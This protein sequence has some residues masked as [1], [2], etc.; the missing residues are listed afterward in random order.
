MTQSTAHYTPAQSP[1]RWIAV[2]LLHLLLGW[3]LVSGTH[4][5]VLKALRQPM[6]TLL[7]KEVALVP[8]APPQP[9]VKA[10]RPYVPPPDIPVAEQTSP[11]AIS[12]STQPAPEPSKPVSV[13]APPVVTPALPEKMEAALVCPGQVRPEIPRQAYLDNIQGLVQAQAT[14]EGGLV[15]EVRIVSGPRIFHEA[16]KTAMRQYKC[17]LQNSPVVAMQSF[18]FRFE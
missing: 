12:V 11:A 14:V 10:P 17:N 18:N 1:A 3:A 15:K 13:S 9:V 5:S 6:E 16:V 8:P 7:I 4:V 2:A